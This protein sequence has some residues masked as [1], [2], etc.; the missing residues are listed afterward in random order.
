MNYPDVPLRGMT[1]STETNGGQD[2]P[3]HQIQGA[4][5]VM[6]KNEKPA[7]DDDFE[8][9]DADESRCWCGGQDA[10]RCRRSGHTWPLRDVDQGVSCPNK[11]HEHD[12]RQKEE[13]DQV[14]IAQTTGDQSSVKQANTDDLKATRNPISK[15][16]NQPV[17]K[18]SDPITKLAILSDLLNDINKRNHS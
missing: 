17:S 15:M 5:W 4:D 9:I 16:I 14:E 7:T 11:S 3:S 13:A 2:N 1:S 12:G 18:Y 6:V 8:L 10:E